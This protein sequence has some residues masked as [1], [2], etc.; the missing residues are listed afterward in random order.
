MFNHYLKKL[1]ESGVIDKMNHDWSLRE[2]MDFEIDPVVIL[3]YENVAF[4][5]MIL[6]GGLMFSCGLTLFG[7]GFR[8]SAEQIKGRSRRA[9]NQ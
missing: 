8:K 5:F 7:K 9:W 4:P 3:G 1:H 6:V 2:E